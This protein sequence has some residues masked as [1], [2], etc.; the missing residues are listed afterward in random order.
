MVITSKPLKEA[1]NREQIRQLYRT[2]FPK[3]E[4]LPWWMLRYWDS[5]NRGAVTAYY[6]GTAFCGFTCSAA[7]GDV[8]FILFFAV[9][10]DLRGQGYGSAILS[11]IKQSNPG[12]KILLNVEPLDEAA[13]NNHQRI[14]RM[15]FYEKNGFQ[16]TGYN[17]REV[18]GVF[19]VLSNT[20]GL[21]E[22]AYRQVFTKLSYGFWRPEIKKVNH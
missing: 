2:A 16:D 17:I 13:P 3:E 19:R 8:L 5:R 22:D 4:R 9:S 7:A 6:D 10:E 15:A 1:L 12:K 21:D 11:H 14:C 18:G 20:P